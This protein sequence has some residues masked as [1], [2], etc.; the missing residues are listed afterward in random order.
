MS[1]SPL[2]DNKKQKSL[3]EIKVDPSTG[4]SE[5]SHITADAA[6]G[7]GS[8]GVFFGSRFSCSFQSSQGAD[9]R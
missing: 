9:G 1:T 6:A 2:K 4:A 7:G 3:R 5:H 8:S